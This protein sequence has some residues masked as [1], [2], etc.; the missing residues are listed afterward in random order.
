MFNLAFVDIWLIVMASNDWSD[1]MSAHA[2]FGYS[3][4]VVSH[5]GLDDNG[6]FV[7]DDVE[8]AWHGWRGKRN[9]INIFSP[10]KNCID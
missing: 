4:G 1:Q 9:G 8:V 3:L 5:K 2:M 10:Q 7:F 6:Q